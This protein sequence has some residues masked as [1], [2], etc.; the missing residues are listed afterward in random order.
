MD[1]PGH[2]VKIGEADPK[3]VAALIDQLASRGFRSADV[4]DKYDDALA[5]LV[6]H[7]QSTHADVQGR[8]LEP[9]GQVGP[10]TWATLFG[11]TP[12]IT[13]TTGLAGAALGVAVSQVG[14]MERPIG[15]NSGPEVNAYLK[16]V[17]VPPGNFWCAA[18]V[19]WCFDQAAKARGINNPWP[20]TGGCLDLFNKVK[21]LNDPSKIVTVREALADPLLIKPGL[22]FILDHGGGQGHTGFVKQSIAGALRTIEGNSNNDGSRNGVGVFELNR[23]KVTDVQLKGFIDFTGA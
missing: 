6:R 2:V 20:R 15:S 21:A 10:L 1:Y 11:A 13:P 14:V 7:F 22:V 9:D 17:N 12:V 16:S 18:F 8:A 5:S 3:I 23:R 4:S 19:H